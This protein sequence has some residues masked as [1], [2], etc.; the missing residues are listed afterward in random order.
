MNLSI[1][2]STVNQP[3]YFEGG[4]GGASVSIISNI[5]PI[6]ASIIIKP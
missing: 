3:L 4:G 1:L 6:L 2:F 5:D